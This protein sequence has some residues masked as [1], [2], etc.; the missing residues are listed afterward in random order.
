MRHTEWLQ[1]TQ[2][3]RHETN[4]SLIFQAPVPVRRAGTQ[5]Q[6]RGR[7]CPCDVG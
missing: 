4:S 7:G 2:M 1:E 3:A 6:P 5:G